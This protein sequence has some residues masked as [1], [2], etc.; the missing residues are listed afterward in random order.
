MQLS[1]TVSACS[2]RMISLCTRTSSSSGCESPHT[3]NTHCFTM[4]LLSVC[5]TNIYSWIFMFLEIRSLTRDYVSVAFFLALLL[6][7]SYE[8]LVMML[9]VLCRNLLTSVLIFDLDIPIKRSVQNPLTKFCLCYFFTDWLNVFSGVH[10]LYSG[11][12]WSVCHLY[13]GNMTHFRSMTRYKSSYK[14]K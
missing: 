6:P 4:S 13:W 10:S 14:S 8:A 5:C 11:L 12:E 7:V 1:P 3:H 9:Y 2:L